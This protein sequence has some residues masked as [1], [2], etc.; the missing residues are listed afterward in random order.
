MGS[1]K[2]SDTG[3][4]IL[5]FYQY[6]T[7]PQGS[8][9]TRVYEFAR[10]W[11]KAG[12]SVTVVTSVYDKS[13]I[14]PRG[15]IS[16]M[17][18]DGID[19]RVINIRLSQKHGLFARLLTFIAYALVASWYALT[20]PAD[21][22]VCSSGPLT[23]GFPGLI[24]RYLRRRPFVFEV[25]DLWPEGA[26]QLGIVR[27]RVLIRIARLVEKRC[28]RAAARV[29]AA[30]E[31]Q[32]EWIRGRHGVKKLA[33][34]PNACDNQLVDEIEGPVELPPW[35]KDKQLVLYTGSLGLIDDCSQLL[36]LAQVLQ[37]RG[38]TDFEVVI[39]GDGKERRLLEEKAA[40]L[41]LANVHF[42]GP[43]S[44]HRVMEWLTVATCA[45]FVVKDVPFLATASPN[46]MFDAFAAGTPVVQATQG[47]IKDLFEREQCGITVCPNTPDTMADAV[48]RIASDEDLRVRLAANS[49]RVAR[50]LFDRSLL[51]ERY[52]GILTEA[53]RC[54]KGTVPFP[55]RE[56]RDSPPDAAPN[57]R[58]VN[59]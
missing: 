15:L 9:S 10:R 6:F 43:K 49:R 51:A 22:V 4:R 20:L 44:K 59:K 13:G 16:H 39:I 29:V 52:L 56:D 31:G 45:M 37:H 8:Y 28:Y 48:E 40:H 19:V 14:S 50:T 47:W 1:A 7:I 18:F 2:R 55:L 12:C 34:I 33:V 23:V 27:N 32:A 53:A 58:N 41:R 26:I 57:G 25:R 46:K 36:D 5:L 38:R 54:G 3:M 35:A 24:A 42:L 11:V 30:S 21:V 17:N